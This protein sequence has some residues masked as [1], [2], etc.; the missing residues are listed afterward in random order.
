MAARRGAAR[1]T[2]CVW[3]QHL[4]QGRNRVSKRTLAQ[5]SCPFLFLRPATSD[6]SIISSMGIL[7]KKRI[8]IYFPWCLFF[9]MMAIGGRR[10]GA[11]ARKTDRSRS[12]RLSGR[13]LFSLCLWPYTC[14]LQLFVT[15]SPLFSA[16]FFRRDPRVRRRAAP[17][18]AIANRRNAG[19]LPSRSLLFAS[20]RLTCYTRRADRRPSSRFCL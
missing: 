5:S 18:I 19:L 16:A 11:R 1:H 8:R 10:R 17:S 12:F 9:R 6:S 2:T 4:T 15:R 14:T 20:P 13:P 7:E 3:Q